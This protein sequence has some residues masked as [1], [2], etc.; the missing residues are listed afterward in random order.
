MNDVNAFEIF[1]MLDLFCTRHREIAM[2]E[3]IDGITEAMYIGVNGFMFNHQPTT[4]SDMRDMFADIVSEPLLYDCYEC[5]DNQY[6]DFTDS[7]IHAMIGQ[8]VLQHAKRELNK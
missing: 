7:Q 5:A 6:K 3:V 4:L 8:A 1:D 2:S